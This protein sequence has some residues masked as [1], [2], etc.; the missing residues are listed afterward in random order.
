MCWLG[1]RLAVASARIA[2]LEDIL[3]YLDASSDRTIE[4]CLGRRES[5]PCEPLV[6]QAVSR[7]LQQVMKLPTHDVMVERLV[8]H[9]PRA[10]SSGVV[11]DVK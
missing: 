9:R 3:E 10:R 4:H 2:E 1:G 6:I 5:I 7:E 8:I 11:G